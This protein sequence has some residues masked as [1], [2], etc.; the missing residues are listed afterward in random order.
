VAILPYLFKSMPDAEKAL[1]SPQMHS[2]LWNQFSKYNLQVIGT[3]PIGSLGVMSKNTGASTLASLHGQRIRVLAPLVMTPLLKSWGMNPTPV[4]PTQVL[5]SMSTGLIDGV[6]D[7]PTPI[8]DQGWDT[9]GKSYVE[10]DA[11]F[12]VDPLVMSSKVYDGLSSSEQ[13]AVT[14]AF[15]KTLT[16]ADDDIQKETTQALATMKSKGIGIYTPPKAAFEQAAK[17]AEPSWD[18]TFGAD[19]I[20]KVRAVAKSQ[21]Q[22]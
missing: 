17:A 10:M 3:W 7:P 9:Y 11:V 6:F 1:N 20:S 4:D 22:G 18:K 19:V 15:K 5:Q 2:A 16:T 13:K 12:N 21:S 14:A 8:T